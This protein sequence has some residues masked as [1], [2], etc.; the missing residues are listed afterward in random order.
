MY[1][2]AG[3]CVFYV[4]YPIVP[5]IFATLDALL[6][7]GMLIIFLI[8]LWA[9][10]KEMQES[11][12]LD[13]AKSRMHLV[14]RRN[15]IFSSIA[16]TS[17][18]VGLTTLSILEW[19]ANE[20]PTGGSDNL[21]IWASFTIAFDNFIGVAAIHGMTSGWL[22]L[23][24]QKRFKLAPTSSVISTTNNNRNKVVSSEN[25]EHSR[26]HQSNSLANVAN[27]KSDF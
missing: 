22:P 16:L 11:K 6:A 5:I 19:V 13:G 20:D 3:N 26:T 18:F 14:I 1:A 24:L 25:E 10:T 23:I 15:I 7:L 2:P 21:R 9:H 8:P 27:V 17:A 4:L 12:G